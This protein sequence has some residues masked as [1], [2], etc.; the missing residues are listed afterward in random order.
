VPD[1]KN[2]KQIFSGHFCGS[3]S[4]KRGFRVG[5]FSTPLAAGP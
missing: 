3:L 2:D 4:K 5:Q 1:G